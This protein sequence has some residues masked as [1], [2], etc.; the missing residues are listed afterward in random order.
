MKQQSKSSKKYRVAPK[1]VLRTKGPYRVLEKATP[2]SYWIQSLPFCEGPGR[3]GRKL[4]GSAT[5]TKNIIFTMVIFK[6]LDR[7][8]TGFTTMS[9]PLV[10]NPMEKC[11]GVI[12]IG[13]HQAKYE[14][15]S[16]A[17]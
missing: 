9:V 16:W 15:R 1:L 11:I 6:K 12:R 5:A 8:D 17:Y 2:I 3:P 10:K 13:T 7:V 14:E 4:K